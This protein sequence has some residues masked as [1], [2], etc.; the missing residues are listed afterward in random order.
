MID[1][2][3]RAVAELASGAEVLILLGRSGPEV[4]RRYREALAGAT[5]EFVNS[6]SLQR[7]YGDETR[8]RWE[9]VAEL[10]V[11]VPEME[12]A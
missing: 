5:D 1:L 9:H 12:P 7:W 4:R 3:W 6:I 11:G 8:G 2:N 10:A